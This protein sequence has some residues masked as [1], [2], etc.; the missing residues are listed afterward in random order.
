M[1]NFGVLWSVKIYSPAGTY[2]KAVPMTEPGLLP[3]QEE[4]EEY[5]MNLLMHTTTVSSV[6]VL[7]AGA[8]VSRVQRGPDGEPYWVYLE[9]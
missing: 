8:F 5:A 1:A 3:T 6:H 2:D 9:E 7:C 4:A